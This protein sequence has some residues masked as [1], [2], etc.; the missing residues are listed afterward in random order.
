MSQPTQPPLGADDAV[1]PTTG[2]PMETADANADLSSGEARPAEVVADSPSQSETP[3]A[4]GTHLSGL[5]D[6]GRVQRTRAAT[7]WASA[8]ALALVTILFVVFIVQN[9][10]R[11][12]I[13]FLWMDGQIA[14]AAALLI[15]A[16]AGALLVGIPAAV[17]I[18]QLR[19]SLRV[20]AG[21]APTHGL[22]SRRKA[23]RA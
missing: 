14:A 18:G 9:S 17:R 1:P 23:K 11:I 4:D 2:A 8:V 13:E 6:Q 19:H 21:T 7:A 15:A 20:N 16:V 5:D 12:T 10:Q 22:L 3:A